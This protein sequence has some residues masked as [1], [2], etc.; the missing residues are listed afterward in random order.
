MSLSALN[1][2]IFLAFL[3]L[4]TAKM[5]AQDTSIKQPLE[6]KLFEY[7]YE[8]DIDN[9]KPLS[10]II[11]LD[12][13]SAKRFFTKS[14]IK[15]FAEKWNLDIKEPQLTVKLFKGFSL[16][17][18]F[19]TN[20]DLRDPAKWYLFFQVYD[21]NR[22][23]FSR[24]SNNASSWHIKYKLLNGATDSAVAEKDFYVNFNRHDPPSGQLAIE[25][26]P[27]LPGEYYKA[28]DSVA[29]LT[30]SNSKENVYAITL[31]QAVLFN[32]NIPVTDTV[33]RELSFKNLMYQI[34]HLGDPAFTLNK[35]NVTHVKTASKKNIGGN[36]AGGAL[37]LL[38]GV[39]SDKSKRKLYTADYHFTDNEQQY[40]CY[41]NYTE[42]ETAERERIRHDDGSVS[43]ES[44]D[45]HVTD[46]YVDSTETHYITVGGDS[47]ANFRLKYLRDHYDYTNI[48]NGHD[49][50]TI[51]PIPFKWRPGFGDVDIKLTGEI[52]G[53]PFSM[54]TMNQTRIKMFTLNNKM[55]VVING[56]NKPD[57][58]K[59]FIP[60]K[61]DTFKIMTIL[62][63]L[64]YE[65]L[66]R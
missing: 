36:L 29:S 54:E 64:P 39:R 12:N 47:I 66:N 65:F 11:L 2:T 55:A 17:P 62:A 13:D 22:F 41:V 30:V 58:G 53:E 56:Y 19:K 57:N 4:V 10:R 49:S 5:S 59:L 3:L 50:A 26:L 24:P 51:T 14:F 52:Y 23:V 25:R 40:H 35:K 46:R 18:K 42:V 37:T 20:L 8:R 28:F 33:D 6:I 31:Q 32:P 61:E 16:Y 38:T 45:M 44:G 1:R 9:P 63:S 7:I 60:V 34:V 15:A 21:I 27:A 48:W 43:N